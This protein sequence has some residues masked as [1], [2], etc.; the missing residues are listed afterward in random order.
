MGRGPPRWHQPQSPQTNSVLANNGGRPEYCWL[1][2]AHFNERN[3]SYRFSRKHIRPCTTSLN[4]STI[5]VRQL[6]HRPSSAVSAKTRKSG[7]EL[8]AALSPSSRGNTAYGPWRQNGLHAGLCLFSLLQPDQQCVCSHGL[9]VKVPLH[10]VATHTQQLVY[11]SLGFYSFSNQPHLQ[12]LAQLN[13]RRR[14][15]DALV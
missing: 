15:G 12:A 11:L 4:Y 5:A 2:R 6:L 10:G 13:D 9:A 8:Q 3:R 14:Y 7:S 1:I